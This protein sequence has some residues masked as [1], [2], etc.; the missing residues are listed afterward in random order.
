MVKGSQHVVLRKGEIFLSERRQLDACNTKKKKAHL[1]SGRNQR[2]DQFSVMVGTVFRICKKSLQV[3][4]NSLHTGLSHIIQHDI[5]R[6]ARNHI[7]AAE[8]IAG[9]FERVTAM[10][11][12]VICDDPAVV[13]SVPPFVRLDRFQASG[14]IMRIA[15]CSMQTIRIDI[16]CN[17]FGAYI[18]HLERGGIDVFVDDDYTFCSGLDD[19]LKNNPCYKE[20]AFKEDL[21]N[22]RKRRTDEEIY[23]LLVVGESVLYCMEFLI[24]LFFE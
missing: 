8:F 20:L 16:R 12:G 24:Y 5:C 18:Q 4:K 22:R 6:D 21:F 17:T 11:Q 9:V 2:S 15:Q 7:N 10:V 1:Q 13:R 19:L 3:G 14:L 23:L